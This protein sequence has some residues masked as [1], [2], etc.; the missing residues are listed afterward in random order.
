MTEPMGK[1]EGARWKR[2]KREG[3]VSGGRRKERTTLRW[4]GDDRGNGEDRRGEMTK[5]RNEEGGREPN[6]LAYEQ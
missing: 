6:S 3:V 5:Y 2:S 4:G 1:T